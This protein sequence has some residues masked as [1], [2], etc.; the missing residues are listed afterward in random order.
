[1]A[2]L[3]KTAEKA[4]EVERKIYVL[5]FHEG[6]RYSTYGGIGLLDAFMEMQRNLYHGRMVVLM[7]K[8]GD[9]ECMDKE[10][11]DRERISYEFAKQ[12]AKVF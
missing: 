8:E 11:K 4:R 9:S 12:Y 3:K 5:S 6:R 10:I 2:T 7:E 1:M